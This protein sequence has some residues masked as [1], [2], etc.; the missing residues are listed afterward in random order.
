MTH[1][2][3]NLAQV[4]A[5]YSEYG[6][7]CRELFTVAKGYKLVGADA[8]GLE[9]RCLAHYMGAF[10]DGDYARQ[11]LEGDIHSYNQQIANIETRD[12][13]K[14]FIY[15]FLYGGGNTAIAE[16]CGISIKQAKKIRKDFLD[17]LPHL[18]A[19]MDLVKERSSTYRFLKSLD[20]LV[21]DSPSDFASLNTL[22]QSAGAII[23]KRA[24]F[25]ADEKIKRFGLDARF[26]GN[27]HDEFQV[28]VIEEDA[29]IVGEILV[30]SITEAGEY[31]NFRCRL[32]GDFKIGNNWSETH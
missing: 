13:A 12:L 23:M 30:D 5:G 21:I 17:S 15:M 3:P 26:V 8:S 16:A 32:D 7:E 28:E 18:R 27:I 31:Y 29:E 22:L 24:L 9:L 11:I 19:L 2:G 1:S 20:G 14:K 4:P 25:V 10:D 6:S